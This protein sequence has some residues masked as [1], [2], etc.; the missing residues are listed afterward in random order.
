MKIDTTL[1]LVDLDGAPI[2]GEG[3]KPATLGSALIMALT[4]Q[5]AGE[6]DLSGEEKF[7]RYEIALRLSKGGKAVEASAEDV[8]LMKQLAAKAFPPLVMGRIWDAID[9]K[10]A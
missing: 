6:Q 2:N 1:A 8:A 7:K 10:G 4:A 9:P 3:Q 5:Y